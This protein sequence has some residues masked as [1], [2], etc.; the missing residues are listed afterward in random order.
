MSHG[1]ESERLVLAQIFFPRL[2]LMK[3]RSKAVQRRGWA[4]PW[5]HKALPDWWQCQGFEGPAFL[6]LSKGCQAGAGQAPTLLR[7][8]KVLSAT[9]P[10]VLCDKQSNA[11][12]GGC[13]APGLEQYHS[14]ERLIR[15]H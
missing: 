11:A 5:G 4:Q 13:M 2:I 1:T 9:A 6:P 15:A 3:E 7:M 10:W 14:S 8:Q 12:V